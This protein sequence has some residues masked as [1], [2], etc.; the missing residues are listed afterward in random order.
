LAAGI[1]A[2]FLETIDAA[3]GKFGFGLLPR[4]HF[5]TVV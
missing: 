3:S 4:L 2:A 5:L 1:D